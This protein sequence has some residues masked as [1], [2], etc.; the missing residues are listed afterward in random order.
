M[1]IKKTKPADAAER[2]RQ[3]A[4][5]DITINNFDRAFFAEVTADGHL[6]RRDYLRSRID[7]VGLPMAD[8]YA[9]AL[10]ACDVDACQLCT[11]SLT[12]DKTTS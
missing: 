5:Y 8:M 2:L 3:C 1:I 10:V 12:G 7:V 4:V 9:T 6:F 11:R